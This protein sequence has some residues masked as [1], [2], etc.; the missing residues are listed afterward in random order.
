MTNERVVLR[1]AAYRVACPACGELH[2]LPQ[3][4]RFVECR[5]RRMIATGD[6]QHRFDEDAMPPAGVP[7]VASYRWSCPDCHKAH[8]E[9]QVCPAV[10]CDRC[11]A[12][13]EVQS[14]QHGPQARL[15]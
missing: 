15:L 9:S 10:H 8:Y 7:I 6:P 12:A 11:G 14:A 4:S 3:D 1:A 5:C 2:F 13:F